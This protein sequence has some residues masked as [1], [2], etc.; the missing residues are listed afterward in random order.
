[1]AKFDALGE[2]EQTVL[3]AIVHVGQG[4]YG[5]TIR[6]EIERRTGREVSVGA[7]Y[8]AFDRLERKGY[9]RSTISDPTPQRG[10]RAKRFISVTAAG[11]AALRR[12]RELLDRMWAG[13]PASRLKPVKGGPS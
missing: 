13:I 8:T 4:A 2:F 12:S 6:E 11:L 5:V 3:L 9:V 10:G 7:L 1:M